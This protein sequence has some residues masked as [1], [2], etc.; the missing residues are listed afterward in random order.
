MAA[1]EEAVEA[2]ASCSSCKMA[3]I[4][5]TSSKTPEA[6][7]EPYK[8]AKLHCLASQCPFLLTLLRSA[9]P[10]STASREANAVLSGR[11]VAAN[12][13]SQEK[14]CHNA[15]NRRPERG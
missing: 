8:N 12:M 7:Q 5:D 3:L 11:L 1:V 13:I 15:C 2:A 4:V 9:T 14:A 6:K 10:S